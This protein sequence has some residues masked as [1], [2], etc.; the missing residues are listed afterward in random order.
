MGDRRRPV[1]AVGEKGPGGPKQRANCR[2]S[3]FVYDVA[4]ALC[5]VA[6]LEE[7]A[8]PANPARTAHLKRKVF[9]IQKADS[10]VEIVWIVRWGSKPAAAE[11]DGPRRA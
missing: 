3:A 6:S 9:R 11:A 5:R 8:R 2:Q 10:P 4:P 1:S 7:E